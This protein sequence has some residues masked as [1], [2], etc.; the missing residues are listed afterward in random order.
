M[1]FNK[2]LYQRINGFYLF[3]YFILLKNQTS[4]PTKLFKFKAV[5]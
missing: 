3:T 2:S 1:H 5:I 4:L